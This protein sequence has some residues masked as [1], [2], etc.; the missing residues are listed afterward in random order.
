MKLFYNQ[1]TDLLYIRL[2]D[3]V[4]QVSNERITDRIVL[5]MGKDDKIVGIEVLDASH[6]L[7]LP[8]LLSSAQF[9]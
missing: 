4:Q 3:R 1:E 6:Q 7:D 2:D 9:V 8:Q 5:D